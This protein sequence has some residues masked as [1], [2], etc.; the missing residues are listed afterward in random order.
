MTPFC[1][2]AQLDAGRRN[3]IADL[4]SSLNKSGDRAIHSQ[5][6][7]SDTEEILRCTRIQLDAA[8]RQQ[9]ELIKSEADTRQE[10]EHLRAL[11]E[12]STRAMTEELTGVESN[13]STCR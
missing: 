1:R 12:R 3:H 5:N 7:A 9:N 8:I 13:V 6:R 11:F 10:M 4:E 2:F